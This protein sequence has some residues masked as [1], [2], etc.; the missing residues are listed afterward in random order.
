MLDLGKKQSTGK[1]VND[2]TGSPTFTLDLTKAIYALLESDKYETYHVT[3][4]GTC[5][6][7]EFAKL[8]FTFEAMPVKVVPIRTEKLGRPASRPVYSV[9]D[10][11]S[12]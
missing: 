1:A 10:N 8:I 2:Q 6:W 9:L 3:N 12:G 11:A 7:F 5:T 4:S